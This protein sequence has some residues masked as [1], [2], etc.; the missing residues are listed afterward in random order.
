MSGRSDDGEN[1]MTEPQV[2]DL[3]AIYMRAEFCN[4][5]EGS[6][7]PNLILYEVLAIDKRV[8]VLLQTDA[9]DIGKQISDYSRGNNYR[10]KKSPFIILRDVFELVPISQ[11]II[12]ACYR[13]AVIARAQPPSSIK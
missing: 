13:G 10:D 7:V 11:E 12:G 8:S 4:Q 9:K 3:V 6:G 5:H 2:G 1:Q